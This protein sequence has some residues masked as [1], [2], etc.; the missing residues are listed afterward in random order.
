[1]PV[2]RPIP[3]AYR[4]VNVVGTSASGKTQV[5]IALARKLGVPH[6]ELDALH[7]E[8]NW[9][10]A[11]IETMG[12]RVAAAVAGDG[13]VV[14]GN[15]SAVRA[16]IWER[17]EA[18]VWLDCSLATIIRR[19]LVRTARRIRTQEEIWPGTGNRERWS[20]LLRRDGL[21]WWILSTYRRRR[22]D[23]PRLLAARPD[24]AVVHLRSPRATAAWLAQLDAQ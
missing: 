9:A 5:A 15:Y 22:R 18:V 24:I 7:W 6:V 8:A 19:Y 13:W 1:M 16:L 11:S 23:Y 14:D 3:F 10:H 17:A 21:L 2:E 12:D 4:R 20:T